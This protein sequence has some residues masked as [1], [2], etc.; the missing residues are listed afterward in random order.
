MKKTCRGRD[1]LVLVLLVGMVAACAFAAGQAWGAW[2]GYSAARGAIAAQGVRGETV[3]TLQAR[4]ADL[5]Q[6][7][8]G[9]VPQLVKSAAEL[10]E[11]QQS[12]MPLEAGASRQLR[13]DV[14]DLAARCGLQVEEVKPMGTGGRWPDPA[15]Q[16]A[17]TPTTGADDVKNIAFL[18]RIP[19]GDVYRRPLLRL[20]CRAGYAATRKFLDQLG[21]LRWRITPVAFRLEQ[22]DLPGTG[23]AAEDETA[24]GATAVPGI[25]AAQESTL[26]LTLVLAL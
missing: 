16:A 14:L 21:G 1:V 9:L 17:V 15:G 25:G 18:G 23:E 19:T 12:L 22:A 13:L 26:R 8:G 5:D 2:Q 10:A 24:G 4:T 3:E 6:Q 20:Q 7:R 11:L